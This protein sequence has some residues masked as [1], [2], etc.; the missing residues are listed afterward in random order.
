M[1]SFDVNTY[2][3]LLAVVSGAFASAL[4]YVAWYAAL[5][6]LSGARAAVLQLSV[7]VLAALA[8]VLVLAEPFG[9]RL[10]LAGALVLG[11]VGL[12]LGKKS[13]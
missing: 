4:G 8:G 9:V 5:K 12:T 13:S 6:H 1:R 10:A 3:V 11:G 2:G 7:P